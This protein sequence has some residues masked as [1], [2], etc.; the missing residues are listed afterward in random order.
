M[1]VGISHWEE[2]GAGAGELDGPTPTFFFA[3][4][5]VVKRAKDWGRA[6]LENNVAEAWHPFCQWA[7]GWLEPIR[8]EGFEGVEAA[9][10]DVLE[11][12]TDPKR[13]HVLSLS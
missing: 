13:A 4:D 1:A 8:G 10:L 6:G 9:Y 2:F 3:P 5:R 7:A 11:G 12:R